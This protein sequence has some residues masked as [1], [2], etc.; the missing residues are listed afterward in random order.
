MKFANEH[1]IRFF[2]I[3][4][5]LI[6]LSN[7]KPRNHTYNALIVHSGLI[8]STI[9]SLTGKKNIFLISKAYPFFLAQ[10]IP[11]TEQI[12]KHFHMNNDVYHKFFIR[13]IIFQM[14]YIFSCLSCRTSVVLLQSPFPQVTLSRN[15]LF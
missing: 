5:K 12:N 9:K 13:N 15:L 1:K 6:V 8:R 7:H 4:S 11:V 2:L 10:S 14:W 3:I